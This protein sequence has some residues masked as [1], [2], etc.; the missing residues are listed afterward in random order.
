[1][2]TWTGSFIGLPC[3]CGEPLESLLFEVLLFTFF[4]LVEELKF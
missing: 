3:P 2:W 4:G 1:L